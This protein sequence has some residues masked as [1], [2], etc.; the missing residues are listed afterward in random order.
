MSVYR[1]PFDPIDGGPVL[2]HLVLDRHRLRG[3]RLFDLTLGRLACHVELRVGTGSAERCVER[4]SVQVLGAVDE[5]DVGRQALRLVDG[6]G[7]PVVEVAFVEVFGRDPANAAVGRLDGDHP[8]LLVESGDRSSLAVREAESSVVPEGQDLVAELEL[9]AASDHGGAV[10]LA[11]SLAEQVDRA[12]EVGD[13]LAMEGEDLDVCIPLGGV[14]L[15]V[16]DELLPE[17]KLGGRHRDPLVLPVRLEELRRVA[18]PQLGERR[19]LPERPLASVLGELEHVDAIGQTSEEAAGL[20]RLELVGVA[21]EDDL[22]A[23][24]VRMHEQRPHLASAHHCRFIDH[25]HGAT[26]EPIAART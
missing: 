17:P 8:G 16:G 24:L 2:D 11:A 12:V 23:G 18:I 14:P 15:P 5:G 19:A 21:N 3:V 10:D 7:V 13:V 25:E 26:V 1:H 9:V 4:F 20:D 6:A 22:A